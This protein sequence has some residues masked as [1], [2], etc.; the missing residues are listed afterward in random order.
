MRV[1]NN[2]II[3]SIF[4]LSVIKYIS[5]MEKQSLSSAETKRHSQGNK[6]ESMQ[7]SMKKKKALSHTDR[8]RRS[9]E[10]KKASQSVSKPSM[11]KKSIDSC[12]KI[13]SFFRKEKRIHVRI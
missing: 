2:I 4:L 6:K 5:T 11:K 8:K 13:T 12:R 9:Q 7:A 1:N 10:I 3:I